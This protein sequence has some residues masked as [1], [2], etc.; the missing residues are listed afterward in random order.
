MA[1]DGSLASRSRRASL[2][3]FISMVAPMRS[4]VARMVIFSL[5]IS[6]FTWSLTRLASS[7][8]WDSPSVVSFACTLKAT[9]GVG[10]SSSMASRVGML[11]LRVYFPVIVICSRVVFSSSVSSMVS[12]FAVRLSSLSSSV[13]FMHIFVGSVHVY[14]SKVVFGHSKSI[15]ATREGSM[16]L[17]L[18]PSGLRL[19]VASSMRVDMAVIASFSCFASVIFALNKGCEPPLLLVVVW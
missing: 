5:S 19:K 8:A 14:S 18:I 4:P 11:K 7:M 16:A 2:P 1:L 15:M 12:S 17:S 13:M 9:F 6:I 10:T 3:F